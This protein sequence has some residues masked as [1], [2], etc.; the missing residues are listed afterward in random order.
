MALPKA[1]VRQRLRHA[2]FIAREPARLPPD[3]PRPS[4]SKSC[5]QRAGSAYGQAEFCKVQCPRT[6]RGR[7]YVRARP[8][9]VKGQC[10]K[11]AGSSY[12]GAALWNE[13]LMHGELAAPP[14]AGA[15]LSPGA[16]CSVFSAAGSA[17]VPRAGSLPGY[18]QTHRAPRKA[19]AAHSGQAPLRGRR[20]FAKCN[21][22]AQRA[23]GAMCGEAL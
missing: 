16:I 13:K 21:A 6:A 15:A 20:N 18:R 12:A 19:R 2:F 1:S 23:G 3:A 14:G 17:R 4:Q 22:R 5:A 7:R 11:G 9:E 8:C 10:T